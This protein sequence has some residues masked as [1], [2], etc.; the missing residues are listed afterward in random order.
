M[1]DIKKWRDRIEN[2][3]QVQKYLCLEQISTTFT[4]NE[5]IELRL[6]LNEMMEIKN[7]NRATEVTVAESEDNMTTYL[8]P[9]VLTGKNLPME[10]RIVECKRDMRT[11]FCKQN[12]KYIIDRDTLNEYIREYGIRVKGDRVIMKDGKQASIFHVLVR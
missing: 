6:L 8:L 12:E 1:V 7:N 3:L 9:T 5:L 10:Y 4:R 11:R 2:L